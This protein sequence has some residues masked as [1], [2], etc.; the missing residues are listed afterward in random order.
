MHN[1]YYTLEAFL[2]AIDRG[3]HNQWT[4]LAYPGLYFDSH[5][6]RFKNVQREPRV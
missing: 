4:S 2:E 6:I 3:I 1:V 5:D